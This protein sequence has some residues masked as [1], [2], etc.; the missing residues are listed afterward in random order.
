M[1]L[2]QA[3]RNA[4]ADIQGDLDREDTA[5]ARSFDQLSQWRPQRFWLAAAAIA[6]VGTA[7]GG[8]FGV[9]ALMAVATLLILATPVVAVLA[10]DRA[11]ALRPEEP[12]EVPQK[13]SNSPA[14]GSAPAASRTSRT[15]AEASPPL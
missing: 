2:N 11:A 9:R 3:E 5:L 1:S 6:L 12:S 14:S 15:T 13:G 10:A 7:V 8:M 4:L